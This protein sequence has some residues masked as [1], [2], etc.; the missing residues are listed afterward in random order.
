[1]VSQHQNYESNY[2]IVLTK[3]SAWGTVLLSLFLLFVLF[4]LS[5]S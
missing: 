3:C 4:L 2:N 5:F 1:M